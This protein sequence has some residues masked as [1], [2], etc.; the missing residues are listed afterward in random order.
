MV[1]EQKALTNLTLHCFPFVSCDAMD[2]RL[3]HSLTV[4]G[5]REIYL[6]I[7]KAFGVPY[8]KIQLFVSVNFSDS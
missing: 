3:S 4:P 5:S 2:H 1:D 6:K 8:N 7:A